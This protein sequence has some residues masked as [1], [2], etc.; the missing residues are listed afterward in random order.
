MACHTPDLATIRGASPSLVKSRGRAACHA[1]ALKGLTTT[2]DE[3]AERAGRV[4]GTPCTEGRVRRAIVAFGSS[5]DGDGNGRPHPR[6]TRA[7]SGAASG[8]ASR[9]P[10]PSPL[11]P[12]GSSAEAEAVRQA[13]A[14]LN[15]ASE[16]CV[17]AHPGLRAFVVDRR[18]ATEGEL[19]V[20]L[21]V[22]F[23][24]RG[25]RDSLALLSNFNIDGTLRRWARVFPEFFPCPFAMMDFDHNGDYLGEADLPAILDGRAAA[26]LGPGFGRVSRP[27]TCFGCVV[28][29]D[30]SH[31]T[32][33][34][35]V[36]VFVDCRPPPGEPWSV[37]YFNSTGRPPPRGPMPLWMERTRARLSEYRAQLAGAAQQAGAAQLS[38]VVSVPVTD[39]DHQE[40]ETECGLYALF[41]IRRRLEGTPYQFFTQQVV[42]D[43]AMTEFRQHVFASYS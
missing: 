38:D 28:N 12:T 21:E 18:L 35:W 13:A 42:P 31:G 39:I 19:R 40:S 6:G 9:A 26:D 37:E 32:G 43:E 33:K 36:A 29:T 17:V 22:D 15:C 10:S 41:Y 24:A 11:L 20:A 16:S 7:R 23:K 25:P 30:T 27:F 5:P 34:H 8:A 2:A 14:K 1:N 4:P 3:C